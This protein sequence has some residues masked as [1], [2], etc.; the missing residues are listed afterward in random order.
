MSDIS[1]TSTNPKFNDLILFCNDIGKID[2][3]APWFIKYLIILFM[4]IWQIIKI[5]L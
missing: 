5:Q 3:L 2:I 4:L 1:S